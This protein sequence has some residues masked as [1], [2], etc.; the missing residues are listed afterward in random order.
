MKRNFLE[1]FLLSFLILPTSIKH[2]NAQQN[3]NDYYNSQALIKLNN[4]DYIGALKDLNESINLGPS[5]GD[6]DY[7]DSYGLRAK[8]N[9][10]LGNYQEALKDINVYINYFPKQEQAYELRH[11]IKYD[12]ED[13]Y[14]AIEDAN[15]M[16]IINPNY[17]KAYTSRGLSKLKLNKNQEACSDFRKAL[18]LLG[19]S[20]LGVVTWGLIDKLCK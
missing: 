4:K 5:P 13:Y 7:K 18:G 11:S 15:I 1:F 12:M 9:Q 8:V 6:F 19:G 10:E 16:L 20:D 2:L 17:G 14:G 3:L